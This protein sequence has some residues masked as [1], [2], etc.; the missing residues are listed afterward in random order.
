MHSMKSVSHS[1]MWGKDG[2]G[3]RGKVG[4]PKFYIPRDW[5]FLCDRQN[6]SE[7]I[8]MKKGQGLVEDN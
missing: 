7:C 4:P 8:A 3:F 6:I 5:H 2:G 1:Y